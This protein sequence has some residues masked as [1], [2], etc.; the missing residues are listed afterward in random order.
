MSAATRDTILASAKNLKRG[1][2][3]V[4]AM[5]GTVHFRE[6]TARERDQY[7]EAQTVHDGDE[8]TFTLIDSGVR[9]VAMACTDES[10]KA[11]FSD[12][13]LEALRGLPAGAVA[14]VA[15]AIRSLSGI[16]GNATADAEKN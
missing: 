3:N 2:V 9:L 11:L 13:D 15:D 5:G 4:A 14:S 10:G 8:S 12:A 1:S 7:W 16:G 6:L